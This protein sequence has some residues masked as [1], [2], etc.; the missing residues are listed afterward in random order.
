[1][2]VSVCLGLQTDLVARVWRYKR[3]VSHEYSAMP[4]LPLSHQDR[5]LR[6]GMRGHA[7]LCKF[8]LKLWAE[9]H[10]CSNPTYS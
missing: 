6:S 7:T 5:P 8:V 4:R 9:D 10:A 1:M 3:T 2:T